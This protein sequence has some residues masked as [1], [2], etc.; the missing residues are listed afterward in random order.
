MCG[1]NDLEREERLAR[2][3][4]ILNSSELKQA[5]CHKILGTTFKDIE[6]AMDAIIK[7]RQLTPAQ[8]EELELRESHPEKYEEEAYDPYLDFKKNKHVAS[9]KKSSSG[10][11]ELTREECAALIA[12]SNAPFEAPP[13]IERPNYPTYTREQVQELL[14]DHFSYKDDEKKKKEDP[15]GVNEKVLKMPTHKRTY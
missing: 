10:Y 2:A 3:H 4:E 11:R 5:I 6:R 15:V 13:P 8:E 14:R 1:F 7:E 12:A 9:P